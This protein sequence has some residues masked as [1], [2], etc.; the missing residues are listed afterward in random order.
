MRVVS[1]SNGPQTTTVVCPGR[2]STKKSTWAISNTCAPSKS[3]NRSK[4]RATVNRTPSR[5]RFSPRTRVRRSKKRASAYRYATPPTCDQCTTTRSRASFPSCSKT[6]TR[7]TVG[8]R[9][10]CFDR[11]KPNARSERSRACTRSSF[12][13]VASESHRKP[14]MRIFSPRFGARA[15]IGNRTCNRTIRWT[16][17]RARGSSIC[18]ASAPRLRPSRRSTSPWREPSVRDYS[19]TRVE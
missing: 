5:R 8:N 9:R 7:A 16:S 11:I 17:W 4:L 6:F 14:R 15:D 2:R 18:P 10:R 13:E 3:R 12:R 1:I 19:R